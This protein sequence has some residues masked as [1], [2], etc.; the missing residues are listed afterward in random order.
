MLIRA[1]G[2]PFRLPNDLPFSG[3]VPSVSE[4]HV[5]LQRLVR[6]LEVNG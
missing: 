5:R 1:I 4:D 6:R 2:S 3:V